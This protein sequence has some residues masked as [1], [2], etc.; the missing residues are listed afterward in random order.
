[1]KLYPFYIV[2]GYD[3]L[4]YYGIKVLYFSQIKN[5]S[6]A[7]IVLL[8]TIFALAS[9][10]FLIISTIINK[11]IGNKKTL[12]TG[13]I[14]NTISIF[15]FI[16]GNGLAQIITAQILSALAFSM[17]NIAFAPMLNESIPNSLKKSEIFSKIDGKAYFGFCIFSAI[18]TILAGFLYDI[19]PYIPMYLCLLCA[20]IATILSAGF[21]EIEKNKKAKKQD[22]EYLIQY[23]NELKEGFIFTIKSERIKALLLS[24]GFIFAIITLFSTYQMTLLKNIGVSAGVIGIIS[25]LQTILKGQGGKFANKYN[26]KYKNKSL[27]GISLTIAVIFITIGII[28]IINIDFKIKVLLLALL[29]IILSLVEGLYNILYKKY[30]NNFT[31]N[32]ILPTIYS[33]NNIYCNFERVIIYSIG[34]FVLTIASVNYGFILMG[35]LF[36]IITLILQLYMKSRLG[37][38]VK[39]YK[40]EDLKYDEF[41]KTN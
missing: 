23:I 36:I 13:N 10:I 1:M 12:L 4:F 8:S 32:E 28:S 18:A 14:I 40:K 38:T 2:F 34:S 37:L 3:M 6:D 5:I 21:K 33:M 15:I 35:V 20:I 29:S 17:K 24:L 31:N 9:I 26:E 16:Y 27:T 30:L 41:N 19:N 11:K 22:K 7:N 39:E 25:M